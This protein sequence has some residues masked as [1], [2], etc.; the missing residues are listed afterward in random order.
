MLLGA[1]SDG[2]PMHNHINHMHVKP[3]KHDAHANAPGV[4]IF[5]ADLYSPYTSSPSLTI[6]ICQ[7]FKLGE[8]SSGRNKMF[9][10]FEST[11]MLRSGV[12]LRQGG[13]NYG[14]IAEE[15]FFAIKRRCIMKRKL[16]FPSTGIHLPKWLVTRSG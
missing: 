13:R 14:Y 16:G 10:A 9:V 5:G 12:C 15:N 8:G 6:R 3:G 11:V 4:A 1:G 2:L 7:A